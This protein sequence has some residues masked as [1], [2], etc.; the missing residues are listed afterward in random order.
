VAEIVARDAFSAATSG[1]EIPPDGCRECR[2]Y[3]DTLDWVIAT[4]GPVPHR[5]EFGR[6]L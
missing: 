6:A 2:D 5:P 1:A 4:L 3:Q